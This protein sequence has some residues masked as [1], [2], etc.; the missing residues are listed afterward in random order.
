[1]ELNEG[2][3]ALSVGHAAMGYVPGAVVRQSHNVTLYDDAVIIAVHDNGAL[4]V[5]IDGVRYGWSVN[6]CKPVRN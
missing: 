3:K 1:M 2:A 6:T 4:D 5:E